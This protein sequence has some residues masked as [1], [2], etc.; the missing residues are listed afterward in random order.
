MFFRNNNDNI[1]SYPT[2]VWLVT[3]SNISIQTRFRHELPLF[4]RFLSPLGNTLKLLL[5]ES[6]ECLLN[7]QYFKIWH[8]QLYKE[9]ETRKT[10]GGGHYGNEKWI[11]HRK[12]DPWQDRHF[13]LVRTGDLSNLLEEQKYFLIKKSMNYSKRDAFY[14]VVNQKSEMW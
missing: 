6:A 4:F 2:L 8:C 3:D 1:I 10:Y 13:V 11:Q 7:P 14:K 12:K 9:N 5:R